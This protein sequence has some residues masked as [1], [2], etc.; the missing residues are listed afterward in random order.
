M[1]KH[2]IVFTLFASVKTLGVAVDTGFIE[3]RFLEL[4]CTTLDKGL[5]RAEEKND[6]IEYSEQ[7]SIQYDIDRFRPAE[8]Y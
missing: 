5:E 1:R 4:L 2:I 7:F 8:I 6:F 3:S